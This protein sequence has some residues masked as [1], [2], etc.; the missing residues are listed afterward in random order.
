MDKSQPQEVITE[1]TIPE[2]GF[3]FRVRAERK[4]SKFEMQFAFQSWCAER[5]N[6]P[7]PQ[8]TVTVIALNSAYNL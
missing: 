6:L 2:K 1:M 5:G 4:L 7:L 3:T 8:K